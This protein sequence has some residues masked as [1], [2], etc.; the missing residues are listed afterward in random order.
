MALVE[1]PTHKARPY[2]KPFYRYMEGGGDRACLLWHRRSGKDDSAAGWTSVA[3]IESKPAVYWHMLP[4]YSQARKALWTAVNPHTG[5][6]RIDEWFP[7][8]I[9][10]TTREQQMEIEFVNGAL[11]Q[12]VGSDSFDRLVGASVKGCVFS[13]YAL[14]KPEAWAY[15]RPILRENKGWA[16]FPST[17]RGRNHW[18]SL[19]EAAVDDPT[20][21]AEKLTALQTDVFTEE[22]L[23]QERR[24]LIR[25]MGAEDGDAKFRQEYLCDWSAALI[26]A[27]W[28]REIDRAETE[29]RITNLPYDPAF[30]VWT[31]WDLGYGDSTAIWF[32]QLHGAQVRV[33]DYYEANGMG[34]DHYAKILR[35]KP[36]VY[37]KHILPHD[38]EHGEL[39]TG[40]RRIDI[41][42][43][44]GIR[45]QIILPAADVD[46]GIQ[47]ARRLIAK[48]WFD[49][50]KCKDGLEAL[51]AYRREWNEDRRCFSPK[52]LHDWS[53]HGADAWR[54]LAC[55][56]PERLTA[57]DPSRQRYRQG[58][59]PRSRWAI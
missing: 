32:V 5:L 15:I 20:W 31:S 41:M 37:E 23:E 22:E 52:P 8:A 58:D 40:K 54:Y 39:G 27:Y 10:R 11:W 43:S 36:Y 44:F 19:Y 56:L 21:F 35:E 14:A 1:L 59:R 9:R 12:V 25:E 30:P 49:K 34:I 26:G 3:A 7:P 2:Q 48:C 47:A 51:R 53:S 50:E 46:D 17:P 42:A 4:E 6:K 28:A 18:C 33:I 55:G 38:A 45:P 16:I 24:E 57:R 29:Q 13:E